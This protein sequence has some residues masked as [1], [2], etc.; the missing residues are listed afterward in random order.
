MIVVINYHLVIIGHCK[1]ETKAK[2]SFCLL[3]QIDYSIRVYMVKQTLY[4]R[5]GFELALMGPKAYF[6]EKY[7]NIFS[8]KTTSFFFSFFF[9][10]FLRLNKIHCMNGCLSSNRFLKLF[11]SSAFIFKLEQKNK[12]FQEIY[13]YF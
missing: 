5:Q 11:F 1:G 2:K 9:N 6:R 3:N 8:L 12:Y 7:Y 13:F 4:I 10:Y